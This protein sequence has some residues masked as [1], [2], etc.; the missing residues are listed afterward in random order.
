MSGGFVETRRIKAALRDAEQRDYEKARAALRYLASHSDV[1]EAID[2]LVRHSRVNR[3]IAPVPTHEMLANVHTSLAI[4]LLGQTGHPRACDRLVEILIEEPDYASRAMWALGSP[5][6]TAAVP[7]LIAYGDALT[8][9]ELRNRVGGSVLYKIGSAEA[10]AA[11]QRW[12]DDD[13]RYVRALDNPFRFGDAR[14]AKDALD[15][16]LDA[17]AA[18]H[19]RLQQLSEVLSDASDRAM[20]QRLDEL[21][22]GADC[23][24]LEDYLV[25]S[26]PVDYHSSVSLLA[27]L[28]IG[29]RGRTRR[30]IAQVLSDAA[31]NPDT[32][33]PQRLHAWGFLI[34][35]EP[36]ADLAI[37]RQIE[38]DVARET[39]AF[40]ATARNGR[41]PLARR[42]EAALGLVERDGT[43][44]IACL[45]DLIVEHAADQSTELAD[46]I[47]RLPDLAKISGSL[48]PS[49]ARALADERWAVRKRA[50][51]L[52]SRAD[53]TEVRS[54]LAECATNE[55]DATLAAELRRL[56]GG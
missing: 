26:S 44:L 20:A 16:C 40:A 43:A 3:S 23:T 42:L 41:L 17:P 33:T 21:L 5:V 31:T 36:T 49:V 12:L 30:R 32:P 51:E 13:R 7:R 39:A 48:A 15:A 2:C 25:A 38:I 50:I 6:N 4:E 10:M 22:K 53:L 11:Y 45:L 47:G 52:L 8:D 37:Y 28:P 56:A 9:R 55:R 18:N 24:R 14:Q 27:K 34:E 19:E 29:D 35:H 1:P 46:A 54:V